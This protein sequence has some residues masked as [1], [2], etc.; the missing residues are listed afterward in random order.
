MYI[1]SGVYFGSTAL[2]VSQDFTFG[3][4]INFSSLSTDQGVFV[5]GGQN[6]G[7]HIVDMLRWSATAS[8]WTRPN[9]VDSSIYPATGGGTVTFPTFI[10]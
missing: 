4:W 6:D 2:T 8:L 1:G 10:L 3:A 9:I 5:Y 7:E